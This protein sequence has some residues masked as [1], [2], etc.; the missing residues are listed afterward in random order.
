MS[1]AGTLRVIEN[2]MK[3]YNLEI[4]GLNETRWNGFGE[5]ITQEGNTLLY[6]GN[7]D[8]NAPLYAGVGILLSRAAKRALLDW[9]PISDRIIT[10]RLN[11]KVRKISIVVCYGPTEGADE[12][13]KDRFYE[14]LDDTLT[15][16][17]KQ[18]IKILL[19]DVNAKLG[20]DNS[21][22]ETVMGKHGEG[23]MNE[24]GTRFA[25]LCLKHELVIGGTLF[26][27]KRC[28]KLTW[29]SPNGQTK[30]QIDHVAV[31][32]KWRTSLLDTRARRGADC[33]SDHHLVTSDVRLKIASI[34]TQNQ[35]TNRPYNTEALRRNRNTANEFVVQLTNRYEALN[36]ES[37]N[38]EENWTKVKELFQKT[39]EETLGHRESRKNPWISQTT[40]EKVQERR[41]LK[42]AKETAQG[43]DTVRRTTKEFNDK[44]KEVKRS[45]RA[46][47]RKWAEDLATKAQE[48]EREGD[49]RELY[50][51]TKT[52]SN[53][54]IK[55][56]K[57]VKNS[58]GNLIIEEAEQLERWRE[59]FEEILN[60]HST[61]QIT[62]V[63]NSSLETVDQNISVGPPTKQEIVNAIRELKNS[64]APGNDNLPPEVF[65]Q[66]PITSANILHPIFCEIWENEQIPKEWKKG[67]LVKLPKKGDLTEC[68]NWRGI[69]LLPIPSKILT[70]VILN[71]IKDTIDSKLR[72]EQA[73]FRKNCSCVDLI[74]T[75]RIILE[76]SME[77]QTPLYL[78]FIDF[79]KAFDSIQRTVIW[80]VLKDY[81][82]PA[83]LVNIVKETYDEYECQVIH[84]NK[85]TDPFPVQ[86]GVKQGCL[87]S[88][89]LFLMVLDKVMKKVNEERRRGIRWKLT[90]ILEDIDYAD[91]LC[92]L[93]HNIRDLTGKINDLVNEGRKMG[94]KIN[95]G[96]TKEMRIN[97]TN[98]ED[99][100]INNQTIERVQ[101]FQ[102]LGSIVTETGGT[103]ED[104]L[105]R[106]KKAKAAFAQL[107]PIWRSHQLRRHTKLKIFETN[108]KSVLLYGCQTWKVS[109]KITGQLQ[110]FINRCLRN[111]LN[112]YWP[113]TI[114]NEDLWST[115]HQ[116]PVDLTIKQR[117]Y[118]WIGHTLRR[119][120]TIPKEALEWNPQ[121]KRRVG[122]PR[123]TWRRTI[124]K[125][126]AEEGKS[127]G[128]IKSMAQ[129]RVRWRSFVEALRPPRDH[130]T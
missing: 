128:E 13:A 127:W 36:W 120:N 44:H 59:H 40:W 68:R 70:R 61:T 113:K 15:K 81:G 105:Q 57:P 3:N 47:K 5:M 26:P 77:Y 119:Q 46:D 96:K 97:N 64:K 92:L 125:E 11:S 7:E 79:E 118:G 130:R 123:N 54:K 42:I 63:E 90:E 20:P 10:A 29:T 16:I 91:D 2:E 35:R 109:Q 21:C 94:L 103:D 86:T 69:T 102:Y 41:Q 71:R 9:K 17:K 66:D 85:L 62:D 25:D 49:I 116:T 87:L 73:G 48:A 111:I 83:K 82:V 122:R 110:V 95:E 67:L 106:I 117:K 14:T 88:P 31:S 76:Q 89:I 55:Q 129:N 8:E 37:N 56:Q 84:Q 12:A 101:Q 80:K 100:V 78:A 104:V 115:C 60:Q 112:I 75:L 4:L 126:I 72:R 28:H 99:I 23:I 98:N 27:H 34:K 53:R 45:F 114:S 6:S 32:R 124:E 24:N 74:N 65:K 43:Q 51:I 30:N 1:E 93:S 107:R 58:E 19:G 18:D 52:L 39:S 108:V 33:G 50:K 38:I 22:Y 121:G